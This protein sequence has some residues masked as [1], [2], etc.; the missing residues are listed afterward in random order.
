LA[1]A[2]RQQS[3]NGQQR[4]FQLQQPLPPPLQDLARPPDTASHRGKKLSTPTM[5][6]DHLT[7][8]IQPQKVSFRHSSVQTIACDLCPPLRAIK[9][10]LLL[11]RRTRCR[12]ATNARTEHHSQQ[13]G[14]VR[15]SSPPCLKQRPRARALEVQPRIV[16]FLVPPCLAHRPRARALVWQPCIIPP[17][18]LHA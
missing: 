9:R 13:P 12:K 5:H 4:A 11:Q 3:A 17:P 16:H 1:Y 2:P 14:T 15:I 18:C 10:R 6:S 7:V 8:A